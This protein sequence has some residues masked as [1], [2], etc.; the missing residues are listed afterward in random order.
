MNNK[1]NKYNEKLNFVKLESELENEWKYKIQLNESINI[2]KQMKRNQTIINL[3][4]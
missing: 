3:N 4:F 1:N 2:I